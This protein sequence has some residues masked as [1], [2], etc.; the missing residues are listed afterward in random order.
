MY[1]AV[2]SRLDGEPEVNEEEAS[3][4][5]IEN[6]FSPSAVPRYNVHVETTNFNH[7]VLGKGLRMLCILWHVS[8]KVNLSYSDNMRCR[9]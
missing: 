4:S 2:G 1:D 5:P 7:R 8:L 9:V 3:D 6:K